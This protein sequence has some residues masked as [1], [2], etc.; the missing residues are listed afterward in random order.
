LVALHVDNL[1]LADGFIQGVAQLASLKALVVSGPCL[2]A[3]QQLQQQQH[4][5]GPFPGSHHH[6][7]LLHQQQQQQQQAASAPGWSSA[8][9]TGASDLP[10]LSSLSAQGFGKTKA[11]DA[12]ATHK[13]APADPAAVLEA[14]LAAL[15]LGPDSSSS[16]STISSS[17]ST[18]TATTTSTSSGSQRSPAPLLNA[19]GM[20]QQLEQPVLAALAA[21]QQQQQAFPAFR[22]VLDADVLTR[23]SPLSQLSKF[24]LHLQQQQLPCGENLLSCASSP[25][26]LS[27]PDVCHLWTDD[28]QL[29]VHPFTFATQLSCQ[30]LHA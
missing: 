20:R 26:S 28:D 24:E 16:T 4:N 10:D 17:T 13:I 1:Q 21:M 18:S 27:L 12:W 15:K 9:S 8:F 25:S 6:H 14:A 19:S 22:P 3:A 2:L 29:D 7:Q 30:G 11:L 23:L 5:L